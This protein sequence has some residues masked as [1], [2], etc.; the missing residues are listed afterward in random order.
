M[1]R[2]IILL[3]L[4]VSISISSAQQDPQ[5]TQY[6][7]NMS[8]VNPAY[9]GSKDAISLGLLYRKQWVNIEDAPS[10]ATLFAHT[11]VGSNVGLGF[12]FISDRIGPVKETNAYG[13]FSYT[14]KFSDNNEINNLAFG[15]KAGFTIHNVGLFDDINFTLIDPGDI[16][17]SQNSN[18]TFFN[19]GAGVF[20]Y[21][22]NYYLGFSM[23]NI[24]NA[25]HLDINGRKIGTEVEHFFLTGG[26][27]FDMSDTIKFK[28]SFMLKTALSAPT[29]LDISANI[30]YNE[31]I[32]GGLTYR[33]GDSFGAMVNFNITPELRVG[34]AY[35]YITSDLNI[36]T[37][38]SHEIMILYDLPSFGSR[39]KCF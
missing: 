31:M 8:V 29:S 9:A 22:N 15:I 13:D 6:M 4:L 10:T 2:Y 27:V 26:Y 38:A 24:L 5:Y 23:P 7:Y 35:D 1:K 19:F 14:L 37:N 16:A 33:T 30:F 25:V 21:T 28:P 11:S 18:N 32:E 39:C 12:S 17:F 34:Y 3:F 20:Y 36:A